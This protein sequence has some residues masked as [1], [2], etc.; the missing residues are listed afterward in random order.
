MLVKFDHWRNVSGRAMPKP[1]ITNT[2]AIGSSD[3]SPRGR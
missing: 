1:T 3:A 2:N